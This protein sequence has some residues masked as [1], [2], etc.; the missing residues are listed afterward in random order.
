MVPRWRDK[1]ILDGKSVLL[2]VALAIH[3]INKAVYEL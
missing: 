3:I 2:R 1:V